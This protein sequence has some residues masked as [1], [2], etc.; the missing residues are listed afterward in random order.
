MILQKTGEKVWL[1]C[2][3][4]CG[5][6]KETEI[7]TMD[8]SCSLVLLCWAHKLSRSPHTNIIVMISYDWTSKTTSKQFTGEKGETTE[9]TWEL[10]LDMCWLK[11][12]FLP[13]HKASWLTSLKNHQM[14]VSAT[15]L[16]F[17]FFIYFT[18]VPRVFSDGFKS[19][20]VQNMCFLHSLNAV[21]VSF[22]CVFCPSSCS[23][24]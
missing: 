2:H 10:R 22:S 12:F 6:T 1:R 4:F 9:P 14:L 5:N 13:T 11:P 8:V 23:N 19:K 15:I 18:A 3:S 20:K 16:N 24:I 21:C 7:K 17:L